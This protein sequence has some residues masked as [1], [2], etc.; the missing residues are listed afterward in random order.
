MIGRFKYDNEVLEGLVREERVIVQR[1]LYCDTFVLAELEIL[2]PTIPSK[3]ICVGLNYMDH[4]RELDMAIPKKPL[5]FLKPPSSVIGHLGKIVYPGMAKRVD[6]EAE[7]AIVIGK[8]CKNVPS[9]DASSVIMGYTCFNDVTARDIQKEDGQWTRAKSFD[10]FA[11]YGP[12]IIDSGLDVSDL[13]IRTRVNGKV[14]QD[15]RTSNL[16]FGVPELIEFIS[17]IMTLEA[18]DV[19]ATGTP[20]GVGE[21]SAGDEVEV[22]IE[23][24]G[25][26]KNSVVSDKQ[27]KQ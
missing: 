14:R 19:I 13:C 26:L 15:S 6:Y 16:I 5:I 4:A 10:T 1:G 17:S 20:P 2:P 3:I 18:G 7:L 8:R 23:G 24:I 22:E 12:F 11:P 25:I 21:L 9:R 27:I